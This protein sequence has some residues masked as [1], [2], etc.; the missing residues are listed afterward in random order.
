M[1]R[2][3]GKPYKEIN[4]ELVATTAGPSAPTTHEATDL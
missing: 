1:F 4:D 3:I 2:I